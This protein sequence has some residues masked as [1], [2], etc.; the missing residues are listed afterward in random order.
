MTDLVLSQ[1]S[2]QIE[3]SPEY[4]GMLDHIQSN[5]PAITV[6]SQNFYKSASQYKNV[7]LDVTDLTPMS[8]LKH[9]LAVIDQTRAALE[10]SY[11]KTSKSK[12]ELKKKQLQHSVMEDGYDKDLLEVEIQELETVLRNGD[13]YV[14]GAVRKLS[15]FVT[16]YNALLEK[17]GKTEFTE[18]DYER[19][20][21]RYH[22][23]TAVKQALIAARSRGGLIDEGNH[24]YLFDMGINGAALQ[25]ELTA[26]FEMEQD[27]MNKGIEPSHEMTINWLEAVAS[28]YIDC[29]AKFAESRG[30]VSLDRLSLTNGEQHAIQNS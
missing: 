24:I 8:S 4:S 14:K 23:M 13:G 11:F 9:V 6:A 2:G 27:L 25:R 17:L 22:I 19:E 15:F 29:G 18:E 26:Y 1:V 7:T 28:K 30:F 3:V 21:S 10:D 5:L 12:I 20:E 16:Q